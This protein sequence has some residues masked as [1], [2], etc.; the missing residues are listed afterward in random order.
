MRYYEWGDSVKRIK[1]AASLIVA[2]IIIVLSVSAFG[3]S[4]STV[5]LAFDTS[6]GY[7]VLTSCLNGAKG[8]IEIPSKTDSGHDVTEIGA[9]AFKNCSMI[10]SVTIPASV[11]KVGSNAFDSCFVL[12]TVTFLGAECEIGASAFI[13]CSS[14]KNVNLPSKLEKIADKAFEDCVALE[15]ITIP[16]TVTSIGTEAFST[17][18]SLAEIEI[19]AAVNV[20]KKNAFIGCSN[21]TAFNVDSANAVYS[22]NGGVLYGPF[23]SEYDSTVFNPKTDKAL[24][25]YPR[26]LTENSF[27]VPSDVKIISNYAFGDNAYIEKIVLPLGLESIEEDAFKN[28]ARLDE[29]NIPSSVT[30]IGMRAFEK[31]SALK[32]VTI[33]S[34]V[35]TYERAFL[36][37]G[38]E[39]AVIEEGVKKISQRAFD[40]CLSL[41]TV[42]IPLSVESIELGAFYNCPSLEE[43]TIPSSVQKINKTAFNGCSES[44][45]LNVEKGSKAHEFALEND[46]RYSLGSAE[47][48]PVVNLIIDSLPQKLNY[49]YKETL[50]TSGLSLKV[51]YADGTTETVTSG[52]TVTPEKLSKTG[53]TEITVTYKGMSDTFYVS[54]TYAWWQMLIRILLLGFLWY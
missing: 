6:K 31:C 54:V 33:P 35:K 5:Y 2:A 52:F 1:K 21:M 47:E 49:Y 34:S 53:N 32:T 16:E 28:C 10:T 44:L 30:K 4:A 45:V 46:F 25:Q 36:A 23:E 22:S 27:T 29:I 14:L 24:I 3:A 7:A 8:A 12:E 19:P 40:S 48:T 13:H 39:S 51:E 20:I 42:T 37:S 41:K 26:G 15:S 43:I 50:N 9:G 18:D 38:L 11:T 17:C